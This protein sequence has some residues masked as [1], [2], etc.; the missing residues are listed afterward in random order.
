M[1][2]CIPC[3]PHAGGAP[4][5]SQ[6]H[7]EVEGWRKPEVQRSKEPYAEMCFLLRPYA[8]AFGVRAQ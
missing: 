7:V 6:V 1:P 4:V 5:A 2:G 3:K 8:K